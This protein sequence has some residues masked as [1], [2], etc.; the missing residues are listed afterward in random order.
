MCLLLLLFTLQM[1]STHLFVTFRTMVATTLCIFMYA[2]PMYASW[3]IRVHALYDTL[4]EWVLNSDIH[5]MVNINEMQFGFVSGKSATDTVFAVRQLREK[6]ITVTKRLYFALFGI[7]DAFDRVPRKVLWRAL[8]SLHLVE[9]FLRIIYCMYSNAWNSVWLN[10]QYRKFGMGV[11]VHQRS[12]LTILLFILVLKALW[13]KLVCH[14]SFF[15]L[16]IRCWATRRGV[17]PSSRHW[18]LAWE[19]KSAMSMWRRPSV[20]YWPWYLQ[21]IPCAVCWSG[22]VNNSSQ[23]SLCTLW[24]HTRCSGITKWLAPSRVERI[25]GIYLWKRVAAIGIHVRWFWPW[26]YH[27]LIIFN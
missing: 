27:T 8:K 6:Y 1:A 12:V 23:R 2:Y 13:H 15:M 7:E 14:R 16:T 20:W 22:V 25:I 18:K 26:F 10:G 24:F 21:E 9:C 3:S 17:S 5:K 11:G 19:V 4:L